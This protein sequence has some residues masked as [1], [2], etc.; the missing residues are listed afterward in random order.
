MTDNN[1]NNKLVNRGITGSTGDNIDTFPIT[2]ED[3]EDIDLILNEWEKRSKIMT[4][5]SKDE[6][7]RM[8]VKETDYRYKINLPVKNIT[9]EIIPIFIEV[10]PAFFDPNVP[11]MQ[12]NRIDK[13]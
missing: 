11:K 1:D 3:P 8:I 4:N 6:L 12:P 13:N 5:L 9:N 10:S 7:K 2:R